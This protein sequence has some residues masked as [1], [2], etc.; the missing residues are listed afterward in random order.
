M[1]SII[2]VALAI[3]T[4]AGML[5]IVKTVSATPLVQVSHAHR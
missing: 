5:K 3:T 4:P 1:N 2:N